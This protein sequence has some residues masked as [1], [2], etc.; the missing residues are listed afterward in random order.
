M[1]RRRSCKLAKILMHICLPMLLC[2][3][4][5]Q[6]S[7]S[8][9][10]SLMPRTDGP[11]P[12]CARTLPGHATASPPAPLLRPRPSCCGTTTGG[13]A[14]VDTAQRELLC[15]C[16]RAC[17][18][19]LRCRCMIQ[20]VH[21]CLAPAISEVHRQGPDVCWQPR[22]SR[23]CLVCARMCSTGAAKV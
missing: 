19:Y 17:C 18:D 14:R 15:D 16:C 6:P 23:L 1:T 11:R 13:G 22:R 10:K 7:C 12:S 2:W 21:L 5:A 8:G 9:L 4:P 20:H 3:H